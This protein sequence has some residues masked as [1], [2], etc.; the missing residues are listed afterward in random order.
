MSIR[1]KVGSKRAIPKKLT[2]Y[3]T[4]VR[5]MSCRPS[6]G[7]TRRANGEWSSCFDLTR[8]FMQARL[9]RNHSFARWTTS[10][11]CTPMKIEEC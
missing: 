10:N 5:R 1:A 2:D 4:D 7:R 11:V 9:T 8:R 3:G 6:D